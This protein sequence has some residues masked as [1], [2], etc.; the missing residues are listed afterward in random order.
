[1][2]MKI[3]TARQQINAP[4]PSPTIPAISFIDAMESPALFRPWFEPAASW[5]RWRTFAKAVFGLP[6]DAADLETFTK[7]TGRTTPPQVPARE[8]WVIVGRRGGKS[9]FAAAL[10]VYGATFRDY[11]PRLKPGQRAYVQVMAAD[12]DQAQEV[13]N[14]IHGFFDEVPALAG[15]VEKPRGSREPGRREVLRLN[16]RVTIRVQV[17]SFRRL[18]GRTVVMAILDE[19]ALWYSAEDSANPDREILRAVR[20][21]ML[22]IPDALLVAISSPYAR[23]GA[24]WEMYRQHFGKADTRVLVWKADTVAMNPAADRQEI[25]RAY[26]EDP[27]AARAEYGAEFREDLESFVSPEAVEAVTVKDRTSLPYDPRFPH[28]A[29]CDPAGGSGQDSMTVTIVRREGATSV[30]CRVVEWKPPFSPD[31]ATKDAAEILKAYHL[32]GVTG[33]HFGGD[34]PKERF[35]AHGIA[36]ERADHPKSDLYQAFLPL[37]NGRRVELLDHRKTLNQLLSL[38]KATG[39]SGKDSISHP[40]NGHDDLVNAVA[41]ACVLAQRRKMLEGHPEPAPKPEPRPGGHAV[42]GASVRHWTCPNG[43]YEQDVWPAGTPASQKRCAQEGWSWD[44][45]LRGGW[46][47]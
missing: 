23:K 33:D 16:N 35:R 40:P 31:E 11:A 22:T 9:L 21:S 3:A 17:A 41:G 25:D 8:A 42:I 30:V 24:L 37:V 26:E 20:P 46:R 18:R 28:Y 13:M 14:Y 39:R 19:I 2:T 47:P 32:T 27:A 43:H 10:A 44:S 29:F 4:S 15:L 38:E 5:A 36:Y 6:M 34:F 12:T 1:M 7:C 45:V